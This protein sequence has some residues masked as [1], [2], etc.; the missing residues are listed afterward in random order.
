MGQL[1]LQSATETGYTASALGVLQIATF[2][3]KVTT[4]ITPMGKNV[5]FMHLYMNIMIRERDDWVEVTQ[6]SNRRSEP[7]LTFYSCYYFV[8]NKHQ[9]L[10][11]NCRQPCLSH[12]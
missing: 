3:C 11:V 5:D 10:F 8:V 4:R 6:H 1:C 2:R 7:E 9:Q 12:S